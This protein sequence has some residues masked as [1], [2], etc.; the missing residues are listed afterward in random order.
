MAIEDMFAGELGEMVVFSVDWRSSVD[1]GSIFL[2]L[3]GF[4]GSK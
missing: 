2:V 3:E 1:G 4:A